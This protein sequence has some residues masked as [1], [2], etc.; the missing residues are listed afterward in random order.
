MIPSNLVYSGKIE[1]SPAR[2]YRTNIQ[3]QNGTGP[4]LGGNT[5]IVNIP[6]QANTFLIP[7]ESYLKFTLSAVLG[8]A[9]SDF[10]ALDAQGVHGVIQRLRVYH[11]SSLLQDIDNYDDLAKVLF[12]YQAAL[13]S[14]QGRLSITSGTN[15]NYAGA[16][17]NNIKAV[18]KGV[19]IGTLAASGTREIGK[20][21]INLVSL[22]GSLAGNKYLPLHFA[23]SSPLRVEIVLKTGAYS[24]GNFSSV[25]I[26]NIQLDN[27]EY[28]AEFLQLSSGA[29]DAIAQRAG[30]S[31]QMVV[32][33]WRNYVYS[34][35]VTNNATITMPVAA[36][37][38]SLKSLVVTPRESNRVGVATYYP[39]A[40]VKN[41][42][43]QWTV[44]IGSEVLPS[45]A[46]NTDA[47]FFS[48]A[49]KCFGS[50]SDMNYQPSI[51]S[52]SFSQN[53]AAAMA[54]SAGGAATTESGAFLIGL[55]CETYQNVDKTGI[56]A[57]MDTTT[58]DIF[59]TMQYGTVGAATTMLYNAFACFDNVIVF[60]NGAAYSRT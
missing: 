32:P 8:A 4:Y 3:P 37:F 21:A 29:I 18:N 17:V 16:D 1:S 38:S 6:T 22:V 11:G 13:D 23:Q 41:G 56:F 51:D 53:V 55:D 10:N 47:E 39:C 24:I 30:G 36:K 34:A 5:V 25:N 42:L 46:P 49:A 12:D 14:T 28:I 27:V 58:S 57:G 31:L 50:L 60:E 35:A 40:H 48:E 19:T 43:A 44:R 59:V 52:T 20:Y 33:D 54:A 15:P 26:G 9:A 2:R 7:S 45:T